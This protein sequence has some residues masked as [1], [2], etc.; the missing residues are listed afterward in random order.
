[1]RKR[2]LYAVIIVWVSIAVLCESVLAARQREVLTGVTT[3]RRMVIN[4][5]I[6][7]AKQQAVADALKIAVQNAFSSL[8]SRHVF[9]SNLDFF[10]DKVHS[11]HSDYIITYSVL[12]GM[13]NNGHYLVGVESKVDLKLLEKIL[14]NARIINPDKDK[15]VLLFFIVEKLSSDLLPKYW[16]GKNPI[17]YA[18]LAEKIIID[19]MINDQFIVTGYD[20]NRPDPSFYNI[21]INS[22]YDTASARDLGR[23]MK[24]DM[25]VFGKASSSEAINR[26]GEQKAFNGDIVLEAYNVKTGEKAVTSQI[27]AVAKSDVD[28]EGNIQA[29]VKAA[30]LSAQDLSHKI[31]AYWIQT[32]RKEH[33]FDVKL[34]GDNFLPRFIA[35]KHRLKQMPEI[36]NMQPREMSSNSAVLEVFYKGN[37]SQFADNVILKTFDTFGLEIVEVTDNLVTI[38][39]IEKEDTSL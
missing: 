36:E 27:Q 5:N 4:H 2:A 18:S 33:A 14:T 34:E 30:N 3:G 11:H 32:L 9:A 7:Q 6:Q 31:N 15:P 37:P 38:K 35:L 24:A 10:Y 17:P 16:W 29:I 12:G 23:E 19:R 20:E 25:I 39:F 28:Q 22:I 8:V 13:E 21:T 26:M 1:M